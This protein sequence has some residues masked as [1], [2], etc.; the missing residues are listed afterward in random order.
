M[1]VSLHRCTRLGQAVQ[2]ICQLGILRTIRNERVIDFIR[3]TF[4]VERWTNQSSIGQKLHTMVLTHV[5]HPVEGPGID[6]GKLN[7]GSQ[8][9]YSISSVFLIK[10][11]GL[12]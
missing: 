11:P 5:I 12:G 1:K 2:A 4:T 6:D 7:N 3:A 8:R 10:I 9:K